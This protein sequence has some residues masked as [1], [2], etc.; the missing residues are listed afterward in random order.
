MAAYPLRLRER[1][2]ELVAAGW[3]QARVA[4]ELGTSTS[5]VE[6]WLRQWRQ[7]GTLTI[8]ASPGRPRLIGVDAE[9]RLAAQ[10]RANRRASLAEHCQLWEAATGVRVSPATMCR[11]IQRL[12]WTRQRRPTGRQP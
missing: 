6:R 2:L 5:T 9:R 10:L 4:A 11:A 8:G 1:A 3:T 7:T 12:G